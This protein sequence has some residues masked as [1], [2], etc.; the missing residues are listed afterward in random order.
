MFLTQVLQ[1]VLSE[2]HFDRHLARHV[3]NARFITHVVHLADLHVLLHE[4]DI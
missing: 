2:V 3:L 4:L 1:E